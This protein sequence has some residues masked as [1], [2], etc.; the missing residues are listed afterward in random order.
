MAGTL[1][2]QFTQD[3]IGG[4]QHGGEGLPL[5][6]HIQAG[7]FPRQDGEGGIALGQAAQDAVGQGDDPAY[8]AA[9]EGEAMHHAG[10][11]QDQGGPIEGPG[12]LVRLH[13]PRP[14][15]DGQELHQVAMLVRA[16]APIHQAAAVL[17]QLHMQEAV[18]GRGR[19]LAIQGKDGDV[20][21]AHDRRVGVVEKCQE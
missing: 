19:R 18:L 7:G 13:L 20:R 4:G 21:T 10:R 15:A 8:G 3:A 14:F 16:D 11:H 6:R 12:A 5:P 2:A 1:A 9:G 17:N